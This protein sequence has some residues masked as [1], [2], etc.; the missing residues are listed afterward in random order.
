MGDGEIAEGQIWQASLGASYY[1]LDNLVAI[2][3]KNK[4]Q[5]TGPIVERY[6]TNP[7]S[8]KWKA[9][10]WHIIEIDGHDIRQII[11]ALDEADEVKGQPVMIVADTVKGKGVPFAEG[12]ATFHHAI[13]TEEQYE[14]A[15]QQ[16]AD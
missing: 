14:I 13:M 5:A 2:L 7:H 3:D 8:D 9:F 12:L 1:K 10:G 16:F 11:D 6:D 4:V 15:R